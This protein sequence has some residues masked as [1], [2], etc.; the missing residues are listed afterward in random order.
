MLNDCLPFFQHMEENFSLQIHWASL[1]NR[2]VA[3]FDEYVSQ[4]SKTVWEME[5]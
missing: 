5:L 1:P 3:Y 2:L 4:A